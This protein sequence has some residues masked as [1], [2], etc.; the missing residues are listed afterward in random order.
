MED[1]FCSE[2]TLLFLFVF[3]LG[4]KYSVYN[5]R[6][7]STQN[8]FQ[9]NY[10]FER[11]VRGVNVNKTRVKVKV[12]FVD[13]DVNYVQGIHKIRSMINLKKL[14]IRYL[15]SSTIF[16]CFLY[17]FLN[18]LLRE[19]PYLCFDEV[20]VPKKRDLKTFLVHRQGKKDD[21]WPILRVP[22]QDWPGRI[23]STGTVQVSP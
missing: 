9:N 20:W 19:L 18:L 8:V 6:T 10:T 7:K 21:R 11:K 23:L 13:L 16:P 3:G 22:V 15:W 5:E 12:I 14:N 2:K 17:F 4:H 1:G